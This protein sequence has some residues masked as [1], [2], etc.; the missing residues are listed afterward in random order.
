[1]SLEKL[2]EFS[3]PD[4]EGNWPLVIV[5]SGLWKR[6]VPRI[7]ARQGINTFGLRVETLRTLAQRLAGLGMTAR[8][9]LPIN[10]ASALALVFRAA[11]DRPGMF[12][13]D[14]ASPGFARV[15]LDSIN[16]LRCGLVTPDELQSMAPSAGYHSDRIDSLAD[17]YRQYVSLKDARGFFDH[18]DLMLEAAEIIVSGGYPE[19]VPGTILLGH[20]LNCAAEKKLLDAIE[21]HLG[22]IRRMEEPFRSPSGGNTALD[23]LRQNLFTGSGGSSDFDDSFRILACHGEA[24]EAREGIRHLLAR[25]AEGTD[26]QQ[27]AILLP[28]SSPWSA[29]IR[30]LASRSDADIPLD[31]HA[32]PSLAETRPGRTILALHELSVSAMPASGLFDLLRSG[33]IRLGKPE[34]GGSAGPGPGYLQFLCREGRIVSGDDW[35]ARL[36]DYA[37]AL[38][39]CA[40]AR[41]DGSADSSNWRRFRRKPGVLRSDSAGILEFQ[42]AV[43]E[44]KLRLEKWSSCASQ[45]DFFS[46]AADILD[47][48]H[49]SDEPFTD[50]GAREQLLRLLRSLPDNGMEFKPN[51]LGRLL[52]MAL[53]Q[54]APPES[55]SGGVLVTDIAGAAGLPYGSVVIMGLTERVWPPPRRSDPFLPDSIAEKLGLVTFRQESEHRRLLFGAACRAAGSGLRLTYAAVK[56]NE[57][58]PGVPSSHALSAEEAVKGSIPAEDERKSVPPVALDG[59]NALDSCEFWLGRSLCSPVTAGEAMARAGVTTGDMLELSARRRRRVLTEWDGLVGPGQAAEALKRRYGGMPSP[60]GFEAYAANPVHFLYTH[61][62]RLEVLEDPEEQDVP[63]SRELGTMAHEILERFL[64]GCRGKG[65]PAFDDHQAAALLRHTGEVFDEYMRENNYR[66]PMEYRL[67][68]QLVGE[69]LLEWLKTIRSDSQGF[70]PLEFELSFGL[71]GVPPVIIKL[72]GEDLALRGRIDRVD[73]STGGSGG[74]LRIIDYKSGRCYYRR[75]DLDERFN[76]GRNLQLGCYAM[77]AAERVGRPVSEAGYTYLDVGHSGRKA[78]KISIEWNDDRENELMDILSGLLQCMRSGFFPPG[79]GKVWTEDEKILCAPGK[80]RLQSTADDPGWKPFR[81]ATHHP[82]LPEGGED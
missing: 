35:T 16:R 9:L 37:E 15:L 7:L 64:G 72:D 1:M 67:L 21:A 77:A 79:D 17:I 51:Q 45:S 44:L 38:L 20:H 59:K 12:S 71:D 76:Y 41:E 43:L 5:P 33:L 25:A 23:S 36:A 22:G 49:P 78:E 27:Q 30:G 73:V 50:S 11:Q 62:M 55:D 26:H 14:I 75:S 70:A 48:Y 34:D 60:T 56:S 52:R 65:F 80:R 74:S 42:K 28:G 29:L 13:E 54:P 10:P 31:L 18:T 32:P 39:E 53:E 57:F 82:E 81:A 8:K 47:R 40:K 66:N 2:F 61:L 46:A 24:G 6:Q 58:S 4:G 63:E 19:A 68:E 3:K 69:A